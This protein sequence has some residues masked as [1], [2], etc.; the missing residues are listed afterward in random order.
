MDEL[1]SPPGAAAAAA[2]RVVCERLLADAET[3][4][5]AITAS[6]AEAQGDPAIL[7]DAALHA[8][9]RELNRSDLVQWLTSNIQHPGGRVEPYVSPRTSAYIGDLV[10]RGI[11]PE[12]AA[13]WRAA[14]GVA[15]RRWIDECLAVIDDREALAQVLDV[16]A[17]SLVQYALDSVSILREVSLASAMG[18][19]GAEALAM[20]QLIASGT[21]MTPDLAEERLSYRLERN[22]VALVLWVDDPAFGDALDE[23]IGRLRAGRPGRPMLVARASA[24]S[25]WVWLSGPDLPDDAHLESAVL[26]AD[27][28]HASVGRRAR[29]LE[30]FRSSYQDALAGQALLT[31]LGADRRFTAYASV[32]L[33]D[34]LTKDRAS[35]ARF[36]SNTLGPLADADRSLR[37]ALLTYVQC[38]FSTT[39]AAARLYLH[40]NTVERRV[41]KADE[42]SIV[43]VEDNP[44]HVSAALLVLDLVPD[45]LAPST[46]SA[47]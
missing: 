40:R 39:R 46:S 43:K 41:S 36:V 23:L 9:D 10:S 1:W 34:S 30:G 45:I 12:F 18:N 26:E 7:A 2:I 25:R 22:H 17:H 16:S 37:Q 11:A 15:W 38:G 31:R 21:P 20:I 29:G 14:L 24:A 19:A 6:A 4:T 27:S 13:G 32:E 42:L 28:V 47:S 5:D 3:L 8:E 35:A 44:V 33:V